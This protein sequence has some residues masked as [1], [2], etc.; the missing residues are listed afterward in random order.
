MIILF[1]GLSF[2]AL[3]HLGNCKMVRDGIGKS[4]PR[5]DFAACIEERRVRCSFGFYYFGFCCC[6]SSRCFQEGSCIS[7]LNKQINR[8]TYCLAFRL[9][10]QPSYN[11]ASH[12]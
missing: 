6:L 9:T 2:A 12:L 7:L 8:N 3:Q 1:C 11:T 4:Q 10:I 5:Y